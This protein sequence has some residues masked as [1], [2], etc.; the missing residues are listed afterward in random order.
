[1]QNINLRKLYLDLIKIMKKFI[2][3]IFVGCFLLSC[4]KI[5]PEPPMFCAKVNGKKWEPISKGPLGGRFTGNAT[6]YL[7][8]RTFMQDLVIN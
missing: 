1:M 4:E 8:N 7:K 3:I 2:L 6:M 5:S